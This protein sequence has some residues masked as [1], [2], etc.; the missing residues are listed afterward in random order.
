MG[1]GSASSDSSSSSTLALRVARLFG[2]V[3]AGEAATAG[4][5]MVNLFSLMLAYYLIKTVREPLILTTGGAEL[6]SYAAAAQAAVLM[7]AVPLYSWFSSRVDRTRL[8]RGVT[9]FFLVCIQ[10]FCLGAWLKMPMLGFVFYVWVGIFSLA[11]IAQFW[12][13]ANDA[14]SQESGER[15]F[16][17]VANGAILGSVVGSY[18]AS[19]LFKFELSP[20]VILEIATAT[21]LV[22]LALY[23]VVGRRLQNEAQR[24]ASAQ[25]T[26]A[27]S[28]RDGFALVFA[29]PYLRL[30]ALLLILLNVVNTTGEYILSSSVL[31]RAA[32][33]FQAA[34]LA[35]SNLDRD[36]FVSNYIG[37]FYGE[38][39]TWVNI[40]GVVLQAFVVARIVKYTGIA[41]ALLALPIVAFGAYGLVAAGAGFAALRVSKTMENATDYSVMNTARAMLWLPTTRDEKYKAKQALDTF[42]VRLGDVISGG[43]VFLGTTWLG[44]GVPQF[45]YANVVVVLAWLALAWLIVRAYR[46]ISAA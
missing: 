35:G 19:W 40:A 31:E 21:I 45:A 13:F 14:Y 2:D 18:G 43:L 29:K 16:P 26:E 25:P 46:E 10:L 32:S 3:R 6:K 27:L 11:M 36:A 28:R 23:A 34:A 33:A 9:L 24:G 15:L 12:S 20:V 8:I 17:V 1:S 5:M 4:L 39:F 38:F 22:H 37:T 7:G 41:G 44:W 30:I 42:F